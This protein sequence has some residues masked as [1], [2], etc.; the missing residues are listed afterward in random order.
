VYSIFQA[1]VA[2]HVLRAEREFLPFAHALNHVGR[3]VVVLHLINVSQDHFANVKGLGATRFFG[4]SVE[5]TLNIF[6]KTDGSGHDP[7]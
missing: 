7:N 4:E 6:W 2:S 3:K 1:K 5:A